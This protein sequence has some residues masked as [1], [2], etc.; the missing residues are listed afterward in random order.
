M[1]YLEGSNSTSSTDDDDTSSASYDD[2]RTYSS[3]AEKYGGNVCYTQ[4]DI[5]INIVLDRC[6]NRGREVVQFEDES[7]DQTSSTCRIRNI[8]DSLETDEYSYFE[9]SDMDDTEGYAISCRDFVGDALAFFYTL[10]DGPWCTN[11]KNLH[12]MPSQ[13]LEFWNAN[14]AITKKRSVP[15]QSQEIRLQSFRG[16]IQVNSNPSTQKEKTNDTSGRLASCWQKKKVM[17]KNNMTLLYVHGVEKAVKCRKK[18]K[19]AFGNLV[20]QII[21]S[22]R[23]KQGNVPSSI[24]SPDSVCEGDDIISPD[25]LC[26]GDDIISPDSLCEGDDIISLSTTKLPYEKV[27]KWSVGRI[28]YFLNH[29]YRSKRGYAFLNDTDER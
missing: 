5:C 18:Y 17:A 24:K 15:L 3:R 4:I 28:R 27:S 12:V 19:H 21:H 1:S 11:T 25:S 16:H 9:S 22:V 26:E 2:E 20:A 23:R 13:S 14:C 6:F 8:D 10:V 29:S 7:D